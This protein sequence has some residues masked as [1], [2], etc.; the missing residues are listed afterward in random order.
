MKKFNFNITHDFLGHVFLGHILLLLVLLAALSPEN[1]YG[2]ERII[3][4]YV[5]FLFL[6]YVITRNWKHS[7]VS[8]IAITLFLG[9]IDNRCPFSDYKSTY[10][11]YLRSPSLGYY[12]DESGRRVAMRSPPMY[13]EPFDLKPAGE[14]AEGNIN[15][16][17]P[18]KTNDADNTNITDEDLDKMLEE[19]EKQSV[20]ENEHLKKAGGGLDQLKDL[21]DMAKK[22]SPYSDDKKSSRDYT[23]AQAQKATY[24]LIDTVKQ[25]KNTMSEMMPLMKVGKNLI[26]LHKQMGGQELMNAVKN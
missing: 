11:K 9:L 26:T 3:V 4:T 5:V 7:F 1:T 23:P 8:A 18:A 2:L 6:A 25:L 16:Y 22:E 13:I 10:N 12:I 20:D 15:S 24:H 21:L 17:S 19:D 14:N